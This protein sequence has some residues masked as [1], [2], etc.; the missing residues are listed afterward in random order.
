[1]KPVVSWIAVLLAVAAPALARDGEPA[2][3]ARIGLDRSFGDGGTVL[4]P[5]GNGIPLTAVADQQGRVVLGGSLGH[6]G[7]VLVRYLKD[8]SL[9]SSF[10]DGGVAGHEEAPGEAVAALARD[11]TGRLVAS[12]GFQQQIIVA[13]FRRDGD[14]DT[15]FANGGFATV[16]IP[17][18]AGDMRE[19]PRYKASSISV[20]DSGRITVGRV[21]TSRVSSRGGTGFVL[22]RFRDDGTLDES[23][24]DA[25]F[26]MAGLTHA[27]PFQLAHAGTDA[28]GQ[29]VIVVATTFMPLSEVQ[30]P[31]LKRFEVVRLLPDGNL[32]PSFGGGDGVVQAA[33]GRHGTIASVVELDSRQ[34][35]VVG[36]SNG[37]GFG[38]LRLRP[39]GR[40]D[41]S[42]GSRGRVTIRAGS[43]LASSDL[44]AIAIDRKD[45]IVVSG[46][47]EVAGV[48]NDEFMALRL[49]G[50]GRL[51]RGFGR[52]GACVASFRRRQ[53]YPTAVTV[54][55][56]G[57]AIVSGGAELPRPGVYPPT[58]ERM[59]SFA[60]ARC[61][62]KP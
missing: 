62:A 26:F 25:G 19:G 18:E 29:K 60:L 27:T 31:E 1:M 39:D 59:P 40:R 28:A 24:G 12:I 49:R 23:F 3:G 50:D 37:R 17:P 33:V 32:D 36:G 4:S 41:G 38:F 61:E 22:A 46:M 34:R 47:N 51:D 5:I 53:A 2:G 11:S 9:D 35:I 15:S 16:P 44:R 55:A 42:F 21:K 8:G 57:D 52:S 45:R 14:L 43:R 13:R 20:D 54:T 6:T 10:G 7:G 56:D 30:R 58:A 48:N